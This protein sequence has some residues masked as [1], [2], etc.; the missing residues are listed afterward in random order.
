MG[1]Y[2]TI[3]NHTKR[4]RIDTNRIVVADYKFNGSAYG[5]PGQLMAYA[6]HARWRGDHVAVMGDGG[7][8]I[9]NEDTF[10]YA[11]VTAELVEEFNRDAPPW[12]EEM[13]VKP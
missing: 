4:E 2:Y 13:A 10:E 3:V 5:R 9:D 12:V 8:T 11:D 6:M 1:T 7:G